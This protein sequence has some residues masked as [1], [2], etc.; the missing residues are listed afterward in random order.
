MLEGEQLCQFV[1]VLVDQVDE[2]HHYPRPALRVPGGPLLLRL[3]SYGHCGID[4][5]RAR[6]HDLRLNLADA[7]I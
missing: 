6:Q 2:L 1:G 5:S 4:V 3:D 7:G